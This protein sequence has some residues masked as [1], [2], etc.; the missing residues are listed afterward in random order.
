M[1]SACKSVD[2]GKKNE[3]RELLEEELKPRLEE[4]KAEKRK[5][6][7]VD[8]AHFVMGSFLGY[9]WCIAR[10]FIPS[11]SGRKRYNILGAIDAITHEL[12]TVCN[13]TYI[14]ALTVCGLL[15]KLRSEY[16]S[17]ILITLVMDNA[18]YQRCAVL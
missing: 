14:N 2:G 8:A 5:V 1:F 16:G 10:I 13:D 11:S 17:K 12:T 9:L 3:Q 18:R 15:E 6:L 7:F 4:A